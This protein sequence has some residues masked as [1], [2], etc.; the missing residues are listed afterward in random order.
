[1]TSEVSSRHL[2]SIVL[3]P[4]SHEFFKEKAL[5][6]KFAIFDFNYIFDFRKKKHKIDCKILKPNKT[7]PN[8]KSEKLEAS[9]IE[10]LNSGE[11]C[12]KKFKC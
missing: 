7:I 8:S 1:M 9:A 12:V 6:T 3:Q 4:R 2:P 10:I 11:F 5:E